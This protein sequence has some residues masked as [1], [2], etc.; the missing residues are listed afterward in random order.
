MTTGQIMLHGF[1][2]AVLDGKRKKV[3]NNIVTNDEEEIKIVQISDA[4]SQL[5]V[6]LVFTLEEFDQWTIALRGSRLIAARTM[7]RFNGG[8]NRG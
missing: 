2:C 5:Q 7:P 8:V 3:H 4:H 6:Q 1:N